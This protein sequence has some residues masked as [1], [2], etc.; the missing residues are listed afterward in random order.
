ML[1]SILLIPDNTEAQDSGALTRCLNVAK[2]YSTALSYEIEMRVNMFSGANDQM[3]AQ[4]ITASTRK[5]KNLFYH[6]AFDRISVLTSSGYVLLIDKVAKSIRMQKEQIPD[7]DTPWSSFSDEE[8][9]YKLVSSKDG[10]SIIET[11]AVKRLGI[12]RIEMSVENETNQL[13][14]VEYFYSDYEGVVF[15]KVVVEFTKTLINESISKSWF[16][17]KSYV[18]K[19]QGTYD[20][21]GD[22]S[23]YKVVQLH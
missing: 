5:Q 8:M 7:F 19:S 18:K 11:G 9:N 6:D 14:R 12:E 10:M 23:D 2:R 4:I 3:P 1:A 21:V 15:R 13:L 16:D 17:L 22:F 20:G